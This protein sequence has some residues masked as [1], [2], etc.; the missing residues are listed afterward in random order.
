MNIEFMFNGIRDNNLLYLEEEKYDQKWGDNISEMHYL[1]TDYCRSIVLQLKSHF[2]EIKEYC[3]NGQTIRIAHEEYEIESLEGKYSLSFTIDTFEKKTQSQ[4]LINLFSLSNTGKY[5]AFLEKFKIFIKEILLKDWKMCTW[6]ID[7]QSEYLGMELYPLIFKT[8]NKMRAFINKVLTYKL[9]VKWMELIGLEDIIKGYNRSNVDFKREV[10]EFNNINDF[11][12]CSTAESLAQLML[13]SKIFETSFAISEA[14][15]VNLHKML[16]DKKTNSIFNELIKLRKVKVDIWKDVFEKY[17]DS[18]IEKSITNFIKNRNHVAHNKLLTM[19]SFEKMKKNIL[20]V[21]VTFDKANVLFLEE[22][23]SDELYETWNAEHEDILDEKIYIHDR[24]MNETGINILFC[25]GIFELFEDKIQELYTA[26]EDAE[27]FSYE[28]AVGSLNRIQDKPIKQTLFSVESNVDNSFN[29]DVCIL[30]DITEGMGEDSYMYLWIE[31]SDMTKMFE[32]KVIY[33][34]GEAHENTMECYY[35]ADSESYFE[36]R[37]LKSFI[38]D[39]K[40]YISDDMNTIKTEV[41]NLSYLAV[42]E[43]ESLPVADFP[44]WNCNQDYI[45]IDDDLYPY[46]HCINCG[47]ESEILKCIR[48]GTLYSAEDGGKDLC[49]YCLEKIEKE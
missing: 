15:S 38:D 39:L 12:I 49:N 3:Y 44:C 36:N 31:K 24:I 20:E 45:S 34:N 2:P 23:P 17:F 43:G 19:A 46:G 22:E 16:A 5:D 33:H 40:S 37:L 18:N 48:C 27:Y 14:E 10:P 29:F 25:E 35:I 47:E 9:G 11:L 6:I 41:N 30:L 13:K 8:E 42:K 28:V 21:E 32:T 1:G 4:L 26:I 7:E